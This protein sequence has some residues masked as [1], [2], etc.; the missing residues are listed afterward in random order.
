MTAQKSTSRGGFTRGVLAFLWLTFGYWVISF[1]IP[2]VLVFLPFAQSGGGISTSDAGGVHHV[3][4]TGSPGDVIAFIYVEAAG[5]KDVKFTT[6]TVMSHG[7]STF[8]S[9]TNA[10][11]QLVLVGLFALISI[12]VLRRIFRIRT[13]PD[14]SSMPSS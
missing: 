5:P 14:Q 11:V 13:S 1:I 3:R 4:F 7:G 9:W 2:F 8:L 10:Y 6:P 12:P